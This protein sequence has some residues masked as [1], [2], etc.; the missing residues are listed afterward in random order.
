MKNCCRRFFMISRFL[1]RIIALR[2]T[3]DDVE[4]AVSTACR[5]VA[6]TGR[7]V[8]VIQTPP[9]RHDSRARPPARKSTPLPVPGWAFFERREDDFARPC[10]M[11]AGGR[12]SRLPDRPSERRSAGGAAANH[13]DPGDDGAACR[14]QGAAGGRT[15]PA[16][17]SRCS[18]AAW[19][20]ATTPVTGDAAPPWAHSAATSEQPNH[21]TRR[22]VFNRKTIHGRTLS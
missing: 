13:R 11:R 16:G 21:R 17:W 10:R 8:V 22:E 12:R 5:R 18:G 2:V 7:Q 15:R 19:R 6:S 4:N 14:G 20:A 3:A 9:Q 1:P